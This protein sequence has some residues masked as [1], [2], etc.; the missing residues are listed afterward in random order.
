DQSG[1]MEF[2]GRQN[3]HGNFYETVFEAERRLFFP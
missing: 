1:R 2:I 3:F